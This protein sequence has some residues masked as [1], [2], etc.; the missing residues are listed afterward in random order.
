[1]AG[2]RAAALTEQL[3]AFSR[4]QLIQPRVLNLND[5]IIDIDKMLRRLIREDIELV[6]KLSPDLGNINADVGQLQQVITNLAINARDAMP[7]GGSLII[8]TSNVFLDENY[9]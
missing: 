5:V 3:L 6:I 4:K 1:A 7:H 8:E 2:Q 9:C